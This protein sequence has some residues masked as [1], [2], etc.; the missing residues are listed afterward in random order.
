MVNDQQ[1]G[2]RKKP[3]AKLKQIAGTFWERGTEE[4]EKGS[5]T[6]VEQEFEVLE[7]RARTLN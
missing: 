4:L 2:S 3:R 7:G 1:M 6:L 5:S